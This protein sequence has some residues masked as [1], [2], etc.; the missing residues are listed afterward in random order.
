MDARSPSPRPLVGRPGRSRNKVASRAVLLLLVSAALQPLVA[1]AQPCYLGLGPAAP[2]E[3]LHYCPS[4]YPVC[5]SAAAACVEVPM[6]AIAEPVILTDPT[7]AP[8]WHLTIHEAIRIAF[9][10][11]Q[12][13]RN[14]GLVDARSDVDIIR[15]SVTT[16]DQMIA[17]AEAGGEWG[18]FDPIWTGEVFWHRTDV[19]PGTSFSGIGNRPSELD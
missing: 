4:E 2:F 11:S 5:P 16:Y 12:V 17:S 13:V 1:Q 15:G 10:N 14:L 7:A 9:D 3:P 6:H 18:I 8:H 19:P